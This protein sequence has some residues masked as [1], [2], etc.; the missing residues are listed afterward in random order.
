MQNQFLRFNFSLIIIILLGM[1]TSGQSQISK[2]RWGEELKEP[3]G[4]DA[5]CK[6]INMDDQYYQVLEST[7]KSLKLFTYK[8]TSHVLQRE[9]E[10]DFEAGTKRFFLPEVVKTKTGTFGVFNHYDKYARRQSIHV[11][12]L[13]DHRF[14]DMKEI[15]DHTYKIKWKFWRH[16]IRQ[17]TDED[18]EGYRISPDSNRVAFINSLS[19]EEDKNTQQANIVVLDDQMNLLWQRVHDF[20]GSDKD[21]GFDDILIDN[22]GTI[23]ILAKRFKEKKEIREAN[24][25]DKLMPD[26]KYVIFEITQ[27]NMLEHEIKLNGAAIPVDAT[28][29]FSDENKEE[30]SITGLYTDE[31]K[32]S[33]IKGTFFLSH[34]NS[35]AELHPFTTKWLEDIA[36]ERDKKKGIGLSELFEIQQSV[37]FSDG[38]V[39]MITEKVLTSID[40]PAGSKMSTI[41]Y[42]SRDL[43]V[44]LFSQ[45]GELI[46][47]VKLPKYFI[48]GD[49]RHKS[50][51][52][53][54]HNDEL[55]LFYNEFLDRKERKAIGK[56]GMSTIYIN[57]AKINSK[58]DLRK[59]HLFANDDSGWGLNPKQ[60]LKYQN[61]LIMCS[62][63]RKKYAFVTAKFREKK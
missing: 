43:F 59:K 51:F 5:F 48:N 39:G 12:E 42:H 7:P 61:R 32:K 41:S 57:Y 17:Y 27:D 54:L 62:H 50:F 3:K 21:L 47:Y 56:G 44:S 36:D 53:T 60:V 46:K 10:L 6:L 40:S 19:T 38:T 11:S 4:K 30:Y 25:K 35:I 24:R 29:S 49:Y 28:I 45:E 15:Y 52:G 13:V 63:K 22:Q 58:G 34:D 31:K 16:G 2:P 9:D 20:S 14:T 37:V 8:T 23:F 1:S 26:Y 55:F 18:A 33:K